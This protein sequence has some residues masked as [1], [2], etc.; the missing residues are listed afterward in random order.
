[1]RLTSLDVFRGMTIAAMILVNTMPDDT[2]YTWLL[3]PK[4]HGFTLADLVF[5]AFL[6]IMGTAMAFSL[7]KY[8]DGTAPITKKVY[9]QIFRRS[10]ILFGLGLILNKLLWN[11]S[12]FEPK[13]FDI[14]HLRIMGVLQRIGVAFFLAALAILNLSNRGLWILAG[15][16][17]I[18]YWLI[19]T[20]IPAPDNADGVFSQLGNFSSYVDRSIIAKGHLH[21]SFKQLGDPEGLFSTLPAM[22]NVLFGYLTGS[23]LKKQPEASRISTNLLMFGLA[24]VVI[25][26]VWG[27]FFPI[28][29]KIWT[30]S[31]VVLTTGWSLII[32]A[33]CYEL[34]DVRKCGKWFKSFEMM[35]LN[36]IAIFFSSIVLLKVFLINNLTSGESV[37]VTIAQLI[38]SILFGW[39]GSVNSGL[40]AAIATVLFWLVIAYLMYRKKWFVKI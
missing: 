11:Y 4:W 8:V 21:G 33:G 29:K 22:V 17:L 2:T 10:I 36:P 18:G 19:L 15:E 28:N 7:S 6:F 30:S 25:G 9:W 12:I 13:F 39:G 3:H 40:F 5:P 23:W 38:T 34:V 31:Y 32:F 27:G 1:M 14:E 26:L 20:F 37:G 16:I 24:A 35:G